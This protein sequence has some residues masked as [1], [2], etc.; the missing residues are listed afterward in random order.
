MKTVRMKIEPNTSSAK[1]VGRINTAKFDATTE[2]DIELQITQ[3]REKW[4]RLQRKAQSKAPL[5]IKQPTK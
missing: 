2:A 3:D 4:Q 1:R 5:A